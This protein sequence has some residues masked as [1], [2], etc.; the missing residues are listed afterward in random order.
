MLEHLPP[1]PADDARYLYAAPHAPRRLRCACVV[2]ARDEARRIVA[3]LE[4]LR[5]QWTRHASS[6]REELAVVLVVNGTTDHTAYQVLQWAAL[7]PSFALA[8]VDVDFPAP[9]AHVGS[10]RGLGLGIGAHLLRALS[11]APP[12]RRLLFSTDAD[13]RLAHDAVDR[14]L[15]ELGRAD[16][17]GANILAGEPD[18]SRIGLLFNRYRDLHAELRYAVYASPHDRH[19][20]HGVFGGAGFGVS[21]S[22]YEGV[23]GLPEVSFD[24]D[25]GMRARLLD[26]GYR[27]SYPRDIVAYTSTRTTGR[28]PWGMA[29]QLAAWEAEAAREEWPLVPARE[30]LLAKYRLKARERQRW[31]GRADHPDRDHGDHRGFEAAWRRYW[32]SSDVQRRHARRYPLLPLPE[33]T[34]QL[35]LAAR[36]ALQH[37]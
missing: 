15:E 5:C 18:T 37:V 17:F 19:P 33:A 12:E 26:G 31:R 23:G 27:V 8:V 4:A 36:A 34:G 30:G 9:R 22:A 32:Y 3:C 10:A 35:E 21:L 7:Y 2:P 28:T 6:L 13:T 24:E 14:G 1:L 20:P 16:A 25:Q 29:K 11:E